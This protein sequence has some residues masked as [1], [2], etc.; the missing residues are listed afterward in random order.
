MLILTDWIYLPKNE[1]KMIFFIKN[2]KTNIL[3]K[4]GPKI[5]PND[6]YGFDWPSGKFFKIAY[7]NVFWPNMFS[8][9]SLR[10]IRGAKIGLS[11][12]SPNQKSKDISWRQI[13]QVTTYQKLTFKY[14]IVF[15][16]LTF[17]NEGKISHLQHTFEEMVET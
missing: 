12:E 13:W 9:C 2:E 7:F 14:L 17:W 4:F 15:S 5:L 8:E 3:K 11:L 1:A 10:H 16:E 6:P